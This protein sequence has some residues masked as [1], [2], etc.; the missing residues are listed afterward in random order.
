VRNSGLGALNG[1]PVKENSMKTVLVTPRSLSVGSDPLLSR[2]RE[3]GYKVLCPSPGVQPTKEQL[4]AAVGDAVGYLAGVEKIDAE[5]LDRAPNLKV[6][7][8]NG[9]GVDNI[10]LEAARARGIAVCRADGANARGVAE[11]TIAHLLSALRGIPESVAAIRQERWTRSKGSEVEGRTLGLVGCGKVARLVA[12]FALG[13]DMKVLAYDLYP[14]RGFQPGAGFTW[15]DFDT[16]ISAS[17]FVSLHCPPLE[18]GLPLIDAGVLKRMKAGAIIINTA[19]A[20]LLDEAAAVEALNSG[21]LRA[22]TVDAFAAEP[23]PDWS[24]VKHPKVIATPHIGGF[25]EESVERATEVAV[26]N[27]LQELS[28]K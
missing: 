12:R 6:I 27:L 8:R 10:D 22:V 7:S 5:V 18:S 26:T 4:L 16:L 14:D 9:T 1:K 25:T 24:F 17:D 13:M 3:A 15:T 11:L 20:S 28:K 2:I 23:P 21:I 19:R